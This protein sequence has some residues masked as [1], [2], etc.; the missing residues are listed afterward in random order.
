LTSLRGGPRRRP[1]FLSTSIIVVTALLLI[2][3]SSASI[4]PAVRDTVAIALVDSGLNDEN[5]DFS[6][7]HVFDTD[8]D[9]QGHGTLVA[10]IAAGIDEDSCPAWAHRVTWISYSVFTAGTAS[11]EDVAD[12]IEQAIR[13]QVDVINVSIAI[14]TD[15][16]AL[17]DSVKRAVESGIVV[18]AAAG[19]NQGMGAGY[20]ARYPG[21]ISVGSLDAAGHPSSFSAI[22]HVNYFAPG[23]DIPAVDRTGARQLVTGTSAA[24]A[25]TSNQILKCLLGVAKPDSTL[26][27]L[28]AHQSKEDNQ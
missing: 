13:D 28:I 2:G 16:R 12:A 9:D 20:P 24:A 27:A 4:T 3:C 22:D 18:V 7:F 5:V 14:G 11:A 26:S 19:N 8:A 15:T 21:V 23:E 6:C 1:A 17:R 25:M 10:S